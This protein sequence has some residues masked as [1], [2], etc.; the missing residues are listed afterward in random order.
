V[1]GRISHVDLDGG[2]I[3]GGELTDFSAS[4]S[5]YINATTRVKLNYIYAQPK[6]R[7]SAN[8]ILLRVQYNPW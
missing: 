2:L 3:Q 8:I 6:D 4:L 1:A 7:G 5:W